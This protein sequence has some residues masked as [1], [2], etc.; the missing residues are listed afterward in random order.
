[1]FDRLQSWLRQK[2]V[3]VY[4]NTFVNEA[5]EICLPL[6]AYNWMVKFAEAYNTDYSRVLR[7][8]KFLRMVRTYLNTV[9]VDVDGVRYV[10]PK[11]AYD[12]L[13]SYSRAYNVGYNNLIKTEEYRRIVERYSQMV[14]LTL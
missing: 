13:V 10:L 12:W 3:G 8:E 6:L 14:C 7:N 11:P 2:N 9:V 5:R 4:H 1:M